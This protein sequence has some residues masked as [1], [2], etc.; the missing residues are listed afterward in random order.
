VS[1]LGRRV[2]VALI[3]APLA[4]VVI[5]YGDAALATLASA[6]AALAAYEFFR[7]ARES[8]SA[9]MSAIG[10]GAAAAVPLLVHAHFLGVLVVPVSAFVLAVLALIALS[11]WMR[12][13]DGKPLTAVATTLL[14]I[15]YTGGT[16]VVRVRPAVL[17][18]RRRRCRGGA[19]RHAAGAPDVGQ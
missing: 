13:V 9:P 5:W 6:L 2:I 14:G 11:I 16:P 3:G 18:V 17:R 1:E 15:V 7:L 12:G 19:R 10:V 8:G 4:L